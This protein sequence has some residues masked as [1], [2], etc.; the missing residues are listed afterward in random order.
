MKTQISEQENQIKQ[1]LQSKIKVHSLLL[2]FSVDKKL[3]DRRTPQ[4]AH[5]PTAVNPG[6]SETWVIQGGKCHFFSSLLILSAWP[7]HPALSLP[8]LRSPVCVRVIHLI[9]MRAPPPAP[10]ASRYAPAMCRAP[11]APPAEMNLRSGS[12][13]LPPTD[14]P[15]SLP[16][17]ISP[18]TGSTSLSSIGLRVERAARGGGGEPRIHTNEM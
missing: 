18:P 7:Q 15:P 14:L 16:P 13:Y 8:R 2:H 17:P 4:R 9:A 3:S 6:P 5:L 12:S 1:S 11:P 10:C